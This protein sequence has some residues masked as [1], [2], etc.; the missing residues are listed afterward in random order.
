MKHSIFIF[1][2][3]VV[4]LSCTSGAGE[5]KLPWEG[6]LKEDEQSAETLPAWQEGYFDIHH[7]NSGRGECTFMIFPDGTT[8]VVDAGEFVN[9]KNSSYENVEQ[10]PNA[11]VRPYKVY[12]EYIRHFMPSTNGR[13]DY[14]MVSHYH[15]DHIGRAESAFATHTEGGYILSGV[16]ALYEDIP[17][18]VLIDRSYPD[19][20]Q[21]KL[22]TT[23]F[24]DLIGDYAKFVSYQRSKNGLKVMR[25]EPGSSSQLKM[26]HNPSAYPEFKAQ[27]WAAS[28]VYWNGKSA[29]DIN[30]DKTFRENAM[31]CATLFSYGKFDYWTSGDG[32]SCDVAASEFIPQTVDAMKANHHM[33]SGTLNSAQMGRFQPKVIVTQSFYKRTVQPHQDIIRRIASRSDYDGERYMFFTN[34]DQSIQDTDP[35]LYRQAAGI[36]GHVVIRVDPGGESY[37]VYMLDDTDFQYKITKTYGPFQ[38]K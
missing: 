26:Q 10:K 33:S 11:S 28:G 4:L 16:T 14:M 25:C 3:A 1:L 31:S 30:A 19:Y 22:Y 9:Y 32:T 24:G 7:I 37:S 29:V 6:K 36:N 15:M 8:L 23:D 21:E 13:L 18:D 2:T 34:I 35:E 20:E 5:S 12:A 27:Q 17:F 38:S